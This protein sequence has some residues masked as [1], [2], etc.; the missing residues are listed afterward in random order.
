MLFSDTLLIGVD[1]GATEVK[2]HAVACDDL[3][4][5]TSFRLRE[6]SAARVYARLSEFEPV[7]VADQ[8]AQ[9]DADD[10][11]QSAVE[12]K[13]GARWVLAAAEAIADV[14]RQCGRRQVLIGLGMPGLKTTD[15]RGICVINNGPRIPDYLDALERRL[16]E[17][18]V[19]LARS[20]AALG[21]DADYCGLG[22]ECAAEGLFRDV[23]SAYYVG[24]GTGVADAMKLRGRLVPF[25]DAKSWIMKSWQIPSALGPTFEKLVSAQSINRVYADLKGGDESGYPEAAA[26][27]GDA[28]AN[29]WMN[30][31]ALVLAELVFERML[32]I[33][34]G[35]SAAPHRGEAYTRLD[36]AHDYCGVVLDR[37]VIGQ[38]V[39][40]IYADPRF[41]PFFT[42]KLTV[43]L[44]ALIADSGDSEL[45]GAYLTAEGGLRP[46]LVQCSRLRAAPALGAAVAAVRAASGESRR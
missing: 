33:M 34:R 19:E 30:T 27:D 29:T 3:N 16:A 41:S 21:S 35:R 40:Q 18:G 4:R 39:G 15:K 31:A 32:T 6:E 25:D 38:R 42:E 36:S 13:Q 44:A 12:V 22:E 5:G 14:A 2:A 28:V 43:H 45:S 10:L 20:I 46:G 23:K 37:V 7:P 11:K 1:G 9:R 17:G 26:A 24:C 8:F